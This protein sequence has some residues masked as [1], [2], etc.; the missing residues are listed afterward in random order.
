V[1]NKTVNYYQKWIEIENK[2]LEKGIVKQTKG[3]NWAIRKPLHKDTVSG[4]VNL[5]FKKIVTLSLALDNWEMIVNKD[6]KK[7]IKELISHNYDKKLLQKFFKDRNNKWEGKDVSKVE[8]YYFDNTNVASRVKIDDSFTAEKIISITDTGIQKIMLNHL[9]KYDEIKDDNV[10]EHPELAFSPEGLDEMNKNIIELNNGKQ[11]QLIFKVRTFEPKGSKFAMGETGNKKDKY[12]EAAKGT[13]LFFAIY[14]DENGKRNYETIPLNIIIERFKQGLTAVPEKNEA[15]NSLLLY[16]CPDDL[17]Y[18]P[19]VEEDINNLDFK[20][21]DKEQ[22]NKIYKMV[23]STSYQCF[24]V[25]HDIANTI[26]NKNEFSALNKMERSMD[27]IMIKDHCIK[28]KIDRL[29][30]ISKA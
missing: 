12:V 26:V 25:R 5:Q 19:T 6:L 28:L 23:S 22:A 30:N 15:D 8:I 24:F 1:I 13:N 4:L 20:N 14:K 9:S 3:E 11:H 18:V 16:L 10:I 17:V 29:G 21:I 27:G 2:K 7:Q